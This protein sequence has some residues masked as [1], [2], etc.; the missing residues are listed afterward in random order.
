MGIMPISLYS[1]GGLNEI[2]TQLP[3]MDYKCPINVSFYY[4][5][6]KLAFC[7]TCC[8]CQFSSGTG[9]LMRA[10]GIMRPSGK[11]LLLNPMW[12]T[13]FRTQHLPLW[14]KMGTLSPEMFN[15]LV[16]RMV[17]IDEMPLLDW[18]CGCSDVD[19]QFTSFV[20]L[21]P[22]FPQRKTP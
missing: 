11:L 1:F 21:L 2:T 8:L 12:R 22:L 5:Y 20:T 16:V 17:L 19:S 15:S 13:G 4:S 18:V 7:I 3:E 10:S 9:M 14:V 6:D